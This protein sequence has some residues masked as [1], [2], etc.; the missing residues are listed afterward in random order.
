M[1]C[2]TSWD[3]FTNLKEQDENIQCFVVEP[4]GAAAAAG[5]SVTQP[6]H[7]IQGGGY[8]MNDLKFLQG[9]PVDGYLE[10]TG[11]Q[12]RDAARRLA[13]EEGIFAGFSSGAN[14]AAALELLNGPLFGHTICIMICDSGLKYLSTD[15]W[16]DPDRNASMV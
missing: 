6:D 12:E 8:S 15:L 3:D 1:K 10:I 14:L 5:Q 2:T 16:P 9:V 7:P 4:K 13:R 11:D